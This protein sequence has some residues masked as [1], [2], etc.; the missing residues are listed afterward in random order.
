MYVVPTGQSEFHEGGEVFRYGRDT[1][2]GESVVIW[3]HSGLRNNDQPTWG[4]QQAVEWKLSISVD[5]IMV[6]DNEQGMFAIDRDAFTRETTLVDGEQQYLAQADDE[7]VTHI[8]DPTDFLNGK[9]WIESGN[10]VDENY[11]QEA[12]H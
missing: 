12:G 4:M 11:H 2:T 10:E 5:T 3:Y 7:C 8:G 6:V 1:D 9:L